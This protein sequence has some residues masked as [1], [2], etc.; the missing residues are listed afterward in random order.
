MRVRGVKMMRLG[1]DMSGGAW[2]GISEERPTADKRDRV[3]LCPVPRTCNDLQSYTHIHKGRHSVRVS[4]KPAPLPFPACWPGRPGCTNGPTA[5]ATNAHGSL[6]RCGVSLAYPWRTQMPTHLCRVPLVG[7]VG[8]AARHAAVG[9]CRQQGGPARHQVPAQGSVPQGRGHAQGRPAAG[10][11][12]G[13]WAAHSVGV[14]GSVPVQGLVTC[15]ASGLAV[16]GP[17]RRNANLTAACGSGTPHGMPFPRSPPAQLCAFYTSGNHAV[18]QVPGTARRT[19]RLLT[20]RLSRGSIR[21]PW[22][23][24][25]STTAPPPLPLP[26]RTAA[27]IGL[28]SPSSMTAWRPGGFR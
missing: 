9:V 26:Q 27:N 24:S 22:A 17:W 7:Q 1:G 13:G 16:L 8:Q 19:E 25:T 4:G 23:S 15:P 21:A 18:C 12:R 6:S 14:A 28:E 11:G 2:W 3:M 20:H 10:K 5:Q